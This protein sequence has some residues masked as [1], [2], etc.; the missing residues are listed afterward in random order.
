MIIIELA[1]ILTY[2][3]VLV[4]KSCSTSS[5]VCDSYGFGQDAK[6]RAQ[7]QTHCDKRLSNCRIQLVA[8]LWIF[9][10]ILFILY[11]P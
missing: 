10:S 1:L 11:C 7:T 8:T 4:I 5:A 6:G 2:T 3:C 9:L